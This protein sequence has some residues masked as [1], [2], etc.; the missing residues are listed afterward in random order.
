MPLARPPPLHGL[1]LDLARSA[2]GDAPGCTTRP[3]R[4]DGQM[5]RWIDVR[6]DPRSIVSF[7][8][9]WHRV[10]SPWAGCWWRSLHGDWTLLCA[11]RESL[12]PQVEEQRKSAKSDV[13]R[14]RLWPLGSWVSGGL[15]VV[16]AASGLARRQRCCKAIA[17]VV[18]DF[19]RAMYRDY[20]TMR[21]R[22]ADR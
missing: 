1:P 12:A 3:P 14:V 4:L 19:M 9:P 7:A 5:D 10:H 20:R 22:I 21:S 8:S 18:T 17:G 15:N 13:A 2:S 16:I 6:A 11:R